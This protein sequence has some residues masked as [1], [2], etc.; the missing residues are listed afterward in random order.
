MTLLNWNFTIPNPAV[1]RIVYAVQAATFNLTC[2][3]AFLQRYI[4]I[5]MPM[6][7]FDLQHPKA[8]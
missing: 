7:P 3:L 6:D 5:V 8:P 1:A 2:S 4:A